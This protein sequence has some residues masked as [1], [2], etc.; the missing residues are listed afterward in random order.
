MSHSH[1][2]PRGPSNSHVR[3]T[4]ATLNAF[5]LEGKDPEGPGDPGACGPREVQI[6]KAG[7][8]EM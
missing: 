4:L 8:H 3:G 6:S 5:Q 1:V 7:T 2:N